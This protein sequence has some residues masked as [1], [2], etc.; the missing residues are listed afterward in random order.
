M[1]SPTVYQPP[2]TAT[3]MP[4]YP[5]RQMTRARSQTPPRRRTDSTRSHAFTLTLL[6]THRIHRT[7]RTH[8]TPT[9]QP[10]RRRDRHTR[11]RL[12]DSGPPSPVSSGLI[13]LRPLLLPLLNALS[14]FGVFG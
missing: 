1:W 11:H 8:R 6:R 2:T 10:P 14:E 3:L 12:L 9:T 13:H 5:S 4:H 7:H